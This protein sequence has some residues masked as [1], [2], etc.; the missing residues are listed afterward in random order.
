MKK[1][2]LMLAM[3]AIGSTM[4]AQNA[5]ITV[6]GV[7]NSQGKVLLMVDCKAP[8]NG[9]PAKPVMAMADAKVGDVTFDMEIPMAES[10]TVSVFHD[11]NGDYKMDM[12]ADGRPAE[13]YVRKAFQPEKDGTSMVLKLYY[14]VF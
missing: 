6:K 3:A 12:D 2:M 10:W 1:L 8:K 11:E 13:G 9:E 14:P 5:H 4:A 7:K